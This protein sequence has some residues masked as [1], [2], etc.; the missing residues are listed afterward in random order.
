MCSKDFGPAL[1][2]QLAHAGTGRGAWHCDVASALCGLAPSA[3]FLIDARVLQSLAAA[4]LF[5][6]VNASIRGNSADD[7]SR[8]AFGLL[9]MT[10]GLAPLLPVHW[11]MCC[12]LDC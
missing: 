9:G 2:H 7:D 8:R 6:Q 12:G 1:D 10:L 5:P 3:A 4:L 11:S